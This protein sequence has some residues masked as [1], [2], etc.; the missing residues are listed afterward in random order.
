MAIHFIHSG[1][2]TGTPALAAQIA[3]CAETGFEI[4]M[5][6]GIVQVTPASAESLA[7]LE[8]RT[9]GDKKYEARQISVREFTQDALAPK[10]RT[11]PAGR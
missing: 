3:A 4:R 7:Y 2:I 9:V 1:R 5:V 11:A 10:G 8:A 6:S